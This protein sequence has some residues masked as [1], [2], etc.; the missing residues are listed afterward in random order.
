[1][2]LSG[3]D[4]ENK[5]NTDEDANGYGKEEFERHTAG[6]QKHWKQK[7][8]EG[9]RNTMKKEKRGSKYSIC[10]LFPPCLELFFA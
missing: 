10:I 1:M 7:R 5:K 6:K 8:N 2:D 9:E 3:D 4:D